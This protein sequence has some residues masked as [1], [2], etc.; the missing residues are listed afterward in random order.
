MVAAQDKGGQKGNISWIRR[1]AASTLMLN[2]TT[3][4][5][6]NQA[7][8]LWRQSY[9]MRNLNWVRRRN[10]VGKYC[11]ETV[12]TISFKKRK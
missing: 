9:L 11:T 10:T 3:M 2:K 6:L 1:N 5:Y 4:T 12:L 8:F 7:V